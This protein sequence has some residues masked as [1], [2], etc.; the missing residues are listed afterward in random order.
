MIYRLQIETR[1]WNRPGVEK[2]ENGLGASAKIIQCGGGEDYKARLPGGKRTPNRWDTNDVFSQSA[3]SWST[4]CTSVLVTHLFTADQSGMKWLNVEALVTES[5]INWSTQT[6]VDGISV[7]RF[8]RYLSIQHAFWT[9]QLLSFS[10]SSLSL[11]TVHCLSRGMQQS[12]I[13][14]KKERLVWCSGFPSREI[15]GIIH[16]IKGG[17]TEVQRGQLWSKPNKRVGS[18]SQPPLPQF[19]IS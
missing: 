13:N 19:Y 6:P 9:D 3:P 17:S 11:F 8:L 2:R 1:I 15:C 5:D 12:L 16:F 18:C 4:I 10:S 14:L 7:W